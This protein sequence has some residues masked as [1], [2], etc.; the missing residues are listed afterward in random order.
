[1]GAFARAMA[2]L[3]ANRTVVERCPDELAFFAKQYKETAMPVASP[4][5]L[6]C[7]AAISSGRT[8]DKSFSCAQAARLVER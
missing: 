1:M 8:E 7:S 3:P 5:R 2:I 6:V 4:T